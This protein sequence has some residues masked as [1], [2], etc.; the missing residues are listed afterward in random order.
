MS[1]ENE[2]NIPEVKDADNIL[3]EAYLL[4]IEEGENTHFD[5]EDD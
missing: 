1:Q 5:I 2:L 3:A 4:S